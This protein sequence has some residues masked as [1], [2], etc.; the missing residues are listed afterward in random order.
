MLAAGCSSKP[1]TV[2][3]SGISKFAS[4]ITGSPAGRDVVCVVQEGGASAEA[5][6]SLGEEPTRW[7]FGFTGAPVAA[8]EHVADPVPMIEASGQSSIRVQPSGAVTLSPWI[9]AVRSP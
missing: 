2:S 6:A 5:T 3:P 8:N 1:Q 9:D 4:C 7:P